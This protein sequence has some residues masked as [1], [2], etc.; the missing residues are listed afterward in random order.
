MQEIPAAVLD[1]SDPDYQ[2][3]VTAK[4]VK[5]GAGE[6]RA[7]GLGRAATP[8]RTAL[9]PTILLY[10]RVCDD[11]SDAHLL[12]VA[13]QHF[14]RHMHH[15]RSRFQV[16][17][18]GRSAGRHAPGQASR[19]HRRDNVRRRVCGQPDPGAARARSPGAA[20]DRFRH[21][22]HGR[23]HA[24]LL[25]G[26]GGADPAAPGP[27]A[28][29]FACGRP[30]PGGN[31]LR[32]AQPARTPAGARSCLRP[33]AGHA[34]AS[35]RGGAGPAEAMGSGARRMRPSHTRC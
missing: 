19:Q 7:S 16:L 31:E 9:P 25:V 5:T 29:R 4:A 30:D 12:S 35:H 14:E 11:P 20:G 26:R 6:P 22:R 10:H 15:L 13:P 2:V 32:P 17:P 24:R 3:L 27:A 33:A 21:L 1:A 34:S 28:F 23:R 18:L 8:S